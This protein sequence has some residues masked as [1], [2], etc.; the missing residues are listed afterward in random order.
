MS[1]NQ[2]ASMTDVLFGEVFICGGQSNM[3]TMGLVRLFFSRL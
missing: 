3:V 2:T 1:G